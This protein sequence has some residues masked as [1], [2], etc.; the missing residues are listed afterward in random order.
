M[1]AAN[2]HCVQAIKAEVSEREGLVCLARTELL[3]LSGNP[4]LLA[5]KLAAV[6]KTASDHLV[7]GALY[8]ADHRYSNALPHLT[9]AATSGLNPDAGL[10]LGDSL[11]ATKQD[12][13][14]QAAWTKVID[15]DPTYAQRIHV[16]QGLAEMDRFGPPHWIGQISR[17]STRCDRVQPYGLV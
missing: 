4:T 14:A 16:R 1:A 11:W 15:I 8:V 2:Q 12:E 13:E 17:R 10:L 9:R 7:V 6:A 5:E 3:L